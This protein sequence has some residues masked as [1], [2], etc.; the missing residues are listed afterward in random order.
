MT[1]EADL[2]TALRLLDDLTDPDPCWYD[3]HGGCQAHGVPDAGGSCPN[4]EAAELLARLSGGP[5]T[6]ALRELATDLILSSAR[7]NDDP[8]AIAEGAGDTDLGDLTLAEV[9]QVA[10]MIA[11]ATITVEI[12]TTLE[13]E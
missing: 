7:D 11:Q 6:V 1:V 8:D 12:P 10:R 9:E 4:S 13:D 3:H 5:R 2:A